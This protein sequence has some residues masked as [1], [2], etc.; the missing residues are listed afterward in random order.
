MFFDR[1][2]Q[3][4]SVVKRTGLF[5]SDRLEKT[6]LLPSLVFAVCLAGALAVVSIKINNDNL[7]SQ[8]DQRGNAMVKYM[9]MSSIFYYHNFD[10]GALDGFV[11]EITQSPEVTFAVFYDDKKAPVTISSK[12]PQDTSS[13]LVYESAIKDDTGTLLGYLALGYSKQALVKSLQKFLGAMIFGTLLTAVAVVIGMNLLVRKYIIRP[14]GQVVFVADRLALG[15][16]TVTLQTDRRDEIG[17]LQTSMGNMVAELRSVVTTAVNAG[18]MVT[19]ESR[20]VFASSGQMAKSATEQAAVAEEVSSSIE[21][22]SSNIRQTAGNAKETETIALKAAEDAREGGTAV[23]LTVSAMKE[24]AGRISVIEEI[25][26]QTNLLALNAAIE[27]ARAGEHG[28][29]FAVVA[30]EVRKLAEKSHAA[31]VEIGQVSASSVEVAVRAGELLATM[32][33]AIEKTA[34]LVQEISAASSEQNAGTAQINTAMQQ[35]DRLIQQNSGASEQMSTTAQELASQAE[36]LRSA[37][38]FFDIG[39]VGRAP[40]SVEDAVKK[41]SKGTNYSAPLKTKGS[42]TRAKP[43]YPQIP[44]MGAE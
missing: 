25:A 35:L 27:A 4:G 36:H 42:Y 22:M 23:A 11:K 3:E 32:V 28:K 24:I 39:A 6:L 41:E 7:R 38:A 37:I 5:R 44:Q 33:P 43:F 15:D 9:A 14:L 10:L 12:A 31:A 17:H 34:Q 20:H 26:R 19:T 16:L 8:M 18:D 30:S 21:Q 40:G 2:H 29:G 13:L 1:Y